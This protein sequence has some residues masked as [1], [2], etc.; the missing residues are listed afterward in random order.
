MTIFVGLALAVVLVLA[1][2]GDL[3]KIG[4][5]QLHG[6]P[7]IIGAF[8][9]QLVIVT[10]APNTFSH[11]VASGIH[12]ASYGLA[13]LFLY[14]NRNLPNLWIAALGGAC[15]FAAIAANGGTM[16]ASRTALAA[17]GI[18][19]KGG[20]DNSA[21][22]AHAKLAFLGDVFSFPKWFPLANVF[23]VGDLLLL[24]GAA[25]MLAGIC[26]VPRWP[27]LDRLLSG[28]RRP[29]VLRSAAIRR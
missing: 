23:S 3:R 17:A 18:Q 6:K 5:I 16:P 21:A 28:R 15:N 1:L 29:V 12:L 11:R 24:L 2:G 8:V 13:I 7:L 26:G 19:E 20:F 22:V 14:T 4:S 10:I 9:L 27:A 25:A